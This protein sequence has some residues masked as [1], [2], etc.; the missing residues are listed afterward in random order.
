MARAA[1]DRRLTKGFAALAMLE[2]RCHQAHFQEPRTK[3]WLLDTLVTPALMYAATVW[4]P[5]LSSATWTQLERPQVCMISRLFHR[6]PSVPHDIVRAELA[7]SPMLVEALFQTVCFIHRV[8]ELPA[9][10]LTRRA[11]EASRQLFEAGEEGIW[12]S[13]AVQWL[14]SHGLDIERLPPFQYDMDSPFTRLTHSQRNRVLR[15][16]LWQLYIRETWVT[17]RQ[18]LSTKMLYYKEQFMTILAD[19]IIQR[20]RYMD[21][22]MSHSPRVAIGQL[23]VSSLR[24]EIE[25]GRAAHTHE[26][27]DYA[28]YA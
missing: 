22:Y 8:R 10:R 1:T 14:E 17:P 23:R 16:D 7:T 6:K 27:S 15:P 26:R 28:N 19:G 13:Q 11:F 12:Y 20:P 25:T 18:S 24:L 3:G 5:G 21:T 4:A 2:C 9:D